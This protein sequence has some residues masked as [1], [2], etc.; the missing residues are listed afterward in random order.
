MGLNSKTLS[1][2]FD[3]CRRNEISKSCLEKFEQVDVN[4]K[5]IV[6]IPDPVTVLFSEERG[7]LLRGACY[8]LL[9]GEKN[10]CEKNP[11]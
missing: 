6:I 9:P 7:L 11:S 4:K 3:S 5:I 8:F 2:I 10:S 1:S